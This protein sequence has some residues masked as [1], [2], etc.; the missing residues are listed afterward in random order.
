MPS[1]IS[2][3][4]WLCSWPDSSVQGQGFPRR[5][6]KKWCETYRADPMLH[7]FCGASTEGELRVDARPTA[8]ANY[9]GDFQ[10]VELLADRYASAFADPPY[11]EQFAAEWGFP[12]PKPSEILKVMKHVVVPG[13]YIGILHLQVVRPVAGLKKIAWHPVFSGTTKH[14][15]CLS[16]FQVES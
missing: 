1:T 7:L 3:E 15:R 16:V 12:Y 11:T 9:V 10:E 2:F 6:W 4:P 14:L 13:G 5:F 8:G